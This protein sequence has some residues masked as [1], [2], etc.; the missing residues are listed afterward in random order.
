MP[1]Y[2]TACPRNCYSTCTLNV[3]VENGKIRKIEPHPLNKATAEG[4]CLKGLSYVERVYSPDR[5][6][7]PLKRKPGK[8]NFEKIS[9]DEALDIITEKLLYLR[10]RYGPQSVLFYTGTGTKGLIN[11]VSHNFWRLF[12]GYTTIYGDLCWPAGLEAT[13]L[14]LGE[15]KD[16]APWDIAN[17]K[18]I[19]MWGKNPAE[20]NIHQMVFIEQAVENGA[21]LVVIDPRR[22]QTSER[23][24]L[25]LQVRP[26]TDGALALA[27]ANILIGNNRIDNEFI[28]NNVLGFEKYAE[29][30]KDFTPEKASEITGLPAE[31]IY[32][33]TELIGTVKPLTIC[34]GFGMQRYTNGGQTMRAIISLLA[35]TG[36]IGR[37][38]AGWIYANLN[39]HI[40]EKIKDPIAFYP[41]EKPDGVVRISIST[42][43]L[44]R[45]ILESRDPPVKMIWVERGNPVA[46]NP[47]TPLTLKAFG[48]LDF[49]V[50]VEQFLTDTAKEADIILPAKSMFEQTDVI[51]AYW[52]D[53]IQIKQKIIEPP[54]EVKPETEIY[55]LLAERLGFSDEDIGDKIPAPDDE[56]I[57]AY[58]EKRLK[59]FPGITLEKLKE[60]PVLS[61]YHQEVAFSDLKFPTPSGK[62]E[63]FSEEAAK[64]WGVD[65][66]PVYKEPFESVK[67]KNITKEYPVYMITPNTKNSIHSQFLN[68]KMIRELGHKP[69]A[70]VNPEDAKE[71]NI[72]N[73]ENIRIFNARGEITVES[74]YDYSL[75]KGCIVVYNGWWIKDNSAVNFLSKQRETDMGYGAAFHE[76]LVEFGKV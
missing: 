47:E 37:P 70:A 38:G 65:P 8:N 46:Q 39:S 24:D 58:L 4:P 52:H 31:Y 56:A 33:L 28:K 1:V 48:K 22:T 32:K 55:R 2:T 21:V 54:D 12:G 44:G 60:G 64:R 43:K 57:E 25:L 19:I 18:L 66:L 75:K 72:K 9:W 5:I 62:I 34:G 49:R 17:A 53:Y 7:H 13:R 3:H 6:L 76:N 63:L 42:A 14:T 68:L 69:L 51:T 73:G 36:N 27:A 35:I 20:T 41:P 11:G 15:N 23:A 61:P 29:M 71:R 26:G 50:V 74:I 59:P 30:V 40:F 16:S 45:D 67:N 10:E